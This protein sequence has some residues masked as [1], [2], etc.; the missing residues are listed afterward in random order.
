MK[1]SV[2]QTVAITCLLVIGFM[3]VSSL[4]SEVDAHPRKIYYR[5]YYHVKFCSGCGAFHL[6]FL[7]GTTTTEGHYTDFD[8]MHEQ[9]KYF[10]NYVHSTS[11]VSSCSNWNCSPSQNC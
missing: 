4:V 11:T 7:F 9:Y 2:C 3:M 5:D 1:M 8:E 10:L 6:T